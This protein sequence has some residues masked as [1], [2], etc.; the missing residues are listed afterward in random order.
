MQ[1][2]IVA[3]NRLLSSRITLEDNPKV[4]SVDFIPYK[5]AISRTN[6]RTIDQLDQSEKV[7]LFNLKALIQSRIRR[8]KARNSLN[9]ETF[10]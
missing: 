2:V 8:Q 6:D 7:W 4:I 10:L 3:R 1:A 9:M 5:E